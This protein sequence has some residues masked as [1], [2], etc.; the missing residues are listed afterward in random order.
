M[1]KKI[2]KYFSADVLDLIFGRNGFCGIKCSLP[3]DYNDPYE[4]FLGVDL[5]ASTECLATFSDVVQELPQLQTTCFSNSPVVAPMWA[6]YANNQSGFVLEFDAVML[7]NCFDD[8]LVRDVT[9]RSEPSGNLVGYLQMAAFRKKP[10]D[11]MRLRDAVLYEAYFSKYSAWSYEQECRLV[12]VGNY[13]ENVGG[14]EILFVP[15]ECLSAIIVGS[16]FCQG[17][18]P[19]SLENSL[20]RNLKW[21]EIEIGKSYPLPFL[22]CPEKNTFVFDGEKITTPDNKCNACSE[23]LADESLLCPWCSI[24][25]AHK[26]E[27]AISNPFRLLDHFGALDEY[28][29][30]YRKVGENIKR[31]ISD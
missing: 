15:L 25:E 12:G 31:K 9:Y 27:A 5:K 3:K 20:A 7:E 23:P 22:K 28:I 11:A 4:L 14:S 24:T 19:S 18:I 1:S 2:Y 10:R 13:T 6:H 26:I 30:S 29:E 16:K 17:G 21:Y 8:A